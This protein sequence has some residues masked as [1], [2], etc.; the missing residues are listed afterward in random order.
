MTITHSCITTSN[1]PTPRA[2]A[3]INRIFRKLKLAALGAVALGALSLPAAATTPI[4]DCGNFTGGTDDLVLQNDIGSTTGPNTCLEITTTY[5]GWINF[6]CNGHT[7]SAAQYPFLVYGSNAHVYTHGCSFNS[8]SGGEVRIDCNGLD[9]WSDGD[10][11]TLNG[12]VV[13][14]QNCANP[15]MT[16]GTYTYT[17]LRVYQTSSP[18]IHGNTIAATSATYPRAY[19]MWID[20]N[21]NP[22]IELNTI[23]GHT[24]YTDMGIFLKDNSAGYVYG[25]TISNTWGVAI[26]QYGG[27]NHLVVTQNDFYGT[28]NGG[29][30]CFY[31]ACYANDLTLESNTLHSGSGPIIDIRGVNGSGEL[32]NSTITGNSGPNGATFGH[33]SFNSIALG[34]VSGNYVAYNT[35]GGYVNFQNTGGFTDGGSNYCTGANAAA[36][37]CN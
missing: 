21:S 23:T 15:Y 24:L 10:Y 26:E 6:Y 29:F 33:P 8:G 37:T 13:L 22:D 34:T 2:K 1:T 35:F 4:T 3:T 14:L 16:G 5:T 20:E 31:V 36:V 18:V 28:A 17:S 9:Y 19:G 11:F 30:G 32:T 7:I 25:N 27:S 12:G